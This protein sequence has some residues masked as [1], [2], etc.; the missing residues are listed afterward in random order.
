MPRL[1]PERAEPV[2]FSAPNETVEA[3]ED[4]QAG[5]RWIPRGTRLSRTDPVVLEK[6]GWFQV[7]YALSEEMNDG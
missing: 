4:I 1:R 6:P 5:S 3:I 7:R 2:R